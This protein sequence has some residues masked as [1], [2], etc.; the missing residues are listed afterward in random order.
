MY[1]IAEINLTGGDTIRPGNLTL[2]VGPNNGG[3]SQLLRDLVTAIA[4]PSMPRKAIRSI[5]PSYINGPLHVL[6]TISSGAQVDGS[7]NAIFDIPSPDFHQ[8]QQLRVNKQHLDN[9]LSERSTDEERTRL[10]EGSLGRHLVSHMTTERRLLLVKRQVNR[11]QNIEGDQTPIEAAYAA[12]QET[13]DWI[14]ERVAAAF[15]TK[16]VLDNTQFASIE[17]RL[18]EFDNLI[19]DRGERQ[20]EIRAL[21][22]LDDQGDGIRSFCGILV[23]ILT[24]LRPVIVVDEP[25]AFLHPP[26]AYLIGQAL[27]ELRNR[28]VQLF[29]ATHSAD[30][31]RGIL[32]ITTEATILRLSRQNGSFKTQI[33]NSDDLTKITE[34]PVLSSARVLDGL[35]YSAVAVTES[36]GDVVLYRDILKDYDTAASIGFINSYSKQLSAK[37][38][39]PFRAMGV[40]CAVIVDFDVLRERTCLRNTFEALGGEWETIRVNYDLFLR[41]VEGS[42]TAKFRLSAAL[43]HINKI[44]K[45][46]RNQGDER[47]QITWLRAR[48]KDVRESASVWGE[49]KKRGKFGL[50]E[51]AQIYDSITKECTRLGLF[52]VPV[53]EREAWLTP[54][55][56]YKAD[57]QK[58]TEVA[59]THLR[60]HPLPEDHL[61]RRFIE[62][63]HKFCN[64]TS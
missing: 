63:V 47:N 1:R 8:P 11:S 15:H 13:L 48:L 31:L 39:T 51:G 45:R 18:G 33:L 64:G 40:P 42:D 10:I 52:I 27:A 25:E 24:S 49:L 3:K 4:F 41:S 54:E 26:Q 36:D 16:L 43:S 22:S 17:F 62:D 55:I 61:L 60:R 57:K 29:V 35:F 44:R 28:G 21:P 19:Q 14:N 32:S 59:L 46:A 34:H 30:V 56:P 50:T 53:G 9:I 5:S 6:Q 20:R 2:A 12:S 38:A 23:S 37:I 7:G 58:W